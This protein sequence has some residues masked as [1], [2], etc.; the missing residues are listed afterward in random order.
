M[1]NRICLLAVIIHQPQAAPGTEFAF[2]QILILLFSPRS[3]NLLYSFI[4]IGRV[5]VEIGKNTHASHLR[6]KALIYC[7]FWYQGI[8]A[9]PVGL[10]I[11]IVS[12]RRPC[13]Q[14][15]ALKHR[16]TGRLATIA[17]SPVFLPVSTKIRIY[18]IRFIHLGFIFNS[19][20]YYF[21]ASTLCY[22]LLIMR[23][24][25]GWIRQKKPLLWKCLDFRA[26]DR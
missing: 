15:V 10:V 2:C 7:C 20:K 22:L 9:R 24:V 19:F 3:F 12:E 13:S 23:E 21:W 25:Y 6:L 26:E 16:V 5:V 4:I 1:E 18:I 11:D 8:Q 14:I 17:L